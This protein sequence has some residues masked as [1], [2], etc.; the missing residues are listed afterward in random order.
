MTLLSPRALHSI[1][2]FPHLQEISF[3][4]PYP[5]D[6]RVPRLTQIVI[7]HFMHNCRTKVIS[8]LVGRILGVLGEVYKSVSPCKAACSNFSTLP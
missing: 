4:D 1:P 8:R 6:G 3:R 7:F 2:R 5:S